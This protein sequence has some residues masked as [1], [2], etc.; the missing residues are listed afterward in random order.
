MKNKKF[1][2]V[3]LLLVLFAILGEEIGIPWWP[4]FP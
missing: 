1:Q 3:V 4:P 2:F